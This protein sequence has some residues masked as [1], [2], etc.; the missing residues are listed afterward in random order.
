[1]LQPC[2][3]PLFSRLAFQVDIMIPAEK[4]LFYSHSSLETDFVI[5]K[6]FVSDLPASE[7]SM[8]RHRLGKTGPPMDLIRQF[9]S[10]LLKARFFS[11]FV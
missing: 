10:R 11:R 6:L 7:L 9:F 8:L 2:V 3:T 5:N 1:M 4:L